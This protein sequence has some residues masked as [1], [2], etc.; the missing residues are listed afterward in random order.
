[1]ALLSHSSHLHVS[2]PNPGSQSSV[3]LMTCQVVVEA[4]DGHI[5]RARA[6]RDCASSTSF[7]TE[8]LA[9]QL[10]LPRRRQRVQVAGIGGDEHTL[11]SRSIVTFTITNLKEKSVDRILGHRWKIEAVVLPKVATKLPVIPVP[12]D[13]DWKHLLGLRLA[14]PEFGTPGHVDILLGVDVFN[15][16]V[17]QGRQQSP[18]GSSMAMN[19]EFG[20]VL[21]GTISRD[22][23]RHQEVACVSSVLA[24]N[25]VLRKFWEVEN[26]DFRSPPYSL[27]EQVVVD[28]FDVNCHR[29]EEGSYIVPL[30]MKKKTDP[31]GETRTMH[32]RPQIL[33]R[34][35]IVVF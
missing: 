4:L 2:S 17:R 5:T 24:G 10:Q 1:M 3:L 16:V 19:T 8:R 23:H 35:T 12:F 32:G 33:F 7:V 20:W 18:P 25:E 27:E 30:P 22:C 11:S 15:R 28:H 9:Q 31:L 21:S 29:N 26:C 13:R 6:L 14:D 34:G